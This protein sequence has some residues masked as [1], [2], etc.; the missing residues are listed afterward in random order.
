MMTRRFGN[1][2]IGPPLGWA[3]SRMGFRLR[4]ILK[5]YC[6]VCFNKSDFALSLELSRE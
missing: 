2:V 5:M 4:R 1:L 6:L 3:G